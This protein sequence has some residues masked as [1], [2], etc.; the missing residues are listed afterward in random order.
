MGKVVNGSELMLEKMGRG[1]LVG[2]ERRSGVMRNG[3]RGDNIGGGRVMWGILFYGI[4]LFND[5]CEGRLRKRVGNVEMVGISKIR[6]DDMED[7]M[8]NGGRGVKRGE[9]ISELGID[10]GKERGE[11][12]GEREG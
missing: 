7:D 6:L 10:N 11:E 3:W 12:L 8:G 2:R 1:M 5:R 9:C 4:R